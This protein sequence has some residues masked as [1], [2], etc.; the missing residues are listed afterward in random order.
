MGGWAGENFWHGGARISYSFLAGLLIYRSNWIIKMKLGFIGLAA[1]FV[2]AVIMPYSKWNWLAEPIVVLVY[3]PLLI[4]VGAGTVLTK[5]WKNICIFSGKISYPLYM[6]HYA[7]MWMFGNYYS[8]HKVSTAQLFF[9]ITTG[10]IL[11]I[12]L[13]YLVM[14][15]YDIPIRKY[16]TAKRSV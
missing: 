13:A 11:L 6:T 15:L 1:L 16:L 2:L 4:A 10:T 14:T 12:G 7:V 5:R 3:F 8:S 9:I